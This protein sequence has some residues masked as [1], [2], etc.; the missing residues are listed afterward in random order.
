MKQQIRLQDTLKSQDTEEWIDL[1][2]YR[3]VGYCWALF[4]KKI[5]VSPNT[6]TVFSILLGVLAAVFFYYPNSWLNIAGMVL[7]VWANMY[8]SADGQL[9]RMTG[10]FSRIGRLLDGFAGILWFFSIYL[11]ITLRLTPE[12][13][14]Y[15]WA[16]A[17]V[18]GYFHSKQAAMAD[19]LRNFHLLFVKDKKIS[20]FDDTAKLGEQARSLTWKNNFFD[21]LIANY[22]QSYTKEQ[23]RWTPQL[24]SFRKTLAARFGED[25]PEKIGSL[26]LSLNQ[27]QEAGIHDGTP[28]KTFREMSKPM[29]KYA[30]ILSFNTRTTALFIS[31][32]IGL[33]WVYFVFELTVMNI[34][35][36]YTLRK[37]EAICKAFTVRLRG[38]D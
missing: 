27:T 38:N 28:P 19:Y 13:G 26:T 7:L 32:F 4:F 34:L 2:F 16:L 17:A 23:E 3:P 6:V 11:A 22:Y 1:L 14:F 25:F 31:L 8:D 20:E 5:N 33:P 9:A 29:M 15:I 21:K 24:Q 10:N 36:I 12:W 35:L 37:Y 18:T 30:N